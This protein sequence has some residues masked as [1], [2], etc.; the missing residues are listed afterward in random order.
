MGSDSKESVLH[1]EIVEE[2][3]SKDGEFF[4]PDSDIGGAGEQLQVAQVEAEMA[5][6][7]AHNEVTPQENFYFNYDSASNNEG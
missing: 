1:D 6:M 2:S 3:V 5:F 7:N 4:S